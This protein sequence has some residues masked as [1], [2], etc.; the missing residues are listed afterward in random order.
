MICTYPSGR[1]LIRHV[2]CRKTRVVGHD[3][4]EL[5]RDA[6]LSTLSLGREP[7]IFPGKMAPPTGRIMRGAASKRGAGGKLCEQQACQS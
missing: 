1:K 4:H 2:L 3:R 7:K 5:A 6:E